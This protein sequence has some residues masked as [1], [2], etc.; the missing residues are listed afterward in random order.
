MQAD[1]EADLV[2]PHIRC[3][4]VRLAIFD[5]AKKLLITADEAYR[6]EVEKACNEGQRLRECC[7]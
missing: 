2:D 6:E 1:F 5:A 3:A 7:K 4:G